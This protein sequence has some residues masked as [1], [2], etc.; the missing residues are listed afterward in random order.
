MYIKR[1]GTGDFNLLFW[2]AGT[3]YI[4]AL[5]ETVSGLD[6]VIGILEAKKKNEGIS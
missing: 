4:Q 2:C 3:F 1:A 6:L 5:A